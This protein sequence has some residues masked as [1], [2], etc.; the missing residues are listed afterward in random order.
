[1]IL[2]VLTASALL[3]CAL[4]EMPD[5]PNTAE[6]KRKFLA[7]SAVDGEDIQSSYYVKGQSPEP[8]R[9]KKLCII[10]AGQSNIDGRV[11]VSD[12][13]SAYSLPMRGMRYIKNTLTG[14]YISSYPRVRWGFDT[15]VCHYLIQNLGEDNLYY[16]KWSHGE[17]SIDKTGDGSSHWTVDYEELPSISNSLLMKF[18]REIR[19]CNELYGTEYEIGAMIWHQGESDRASYSATAAANYYTNLKNLIAYCRGIVG[20]SRLPFIM[21]TVSR[22]S[23]QYDDTVDAAIRRLASEDNYVWLVDLQNASLLDAYHFDAAWSEYFGKKVYDCL[24]DAGVISGTKLNP[25][26]PG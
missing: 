25:S 23:D 26:E 12:L 1:M 16:I 13:P 21:G 22:S 4:A 9:T 18:E 7:D 10:G 3:A 19:T 15:I 11:P 24:I 8:A 6:D 14:N 17:T 20:N 5:E 2:A